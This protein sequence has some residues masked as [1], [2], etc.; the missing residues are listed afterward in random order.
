MKTAETLSS[1]LCVVSL[2]QTL[3]SQVMSDWLMPY[4]KRGPPG[5]RADHSG[6]TGHAAHAV[7]SQLYSL[8]LQPQTR[9]PS[10]ATQL[11]C[12]HACVSG[13]L[14]D[15]QGAKIILIL[16][17]EAAVVADNTGVCTCDSISSHGT[18]SS[19]VTSP[20]CS[21]CR[22]VASSSLADTSFSLGRR[23]GMA[24][25]LP[26]SLS[27]TLL[28]GSLQWL[29]SSG[30][31]LTVIPHSSFLPLSRQW[32]QAGKGVALGDYRG[33]LPFTFPAAVQ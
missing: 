32:H 4:T 9:S 11:T 16:Q 14:E 13:R 27:S 8:G 6:G 30:W 31:T 22:M 21:P 7:G 5:N 10:L 24:S 20:S 17:R 28:L 12:D 18:S 29:L 25:S 33:S 26:A 19:S 3:C 2:L 23:G 1:F 15:R